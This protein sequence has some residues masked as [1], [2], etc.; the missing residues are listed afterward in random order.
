[1]NSSIYNTFALL[2]ILFLFNACTKVIDIELEEGKERI[3]IDA[4]IQWEKGTIGNE[5]SISL[6]TSLGYFDNGTTPVTGAEVNILNS[7]TGDTYLFQD[8]N[9]G[10]YSTDSF[11][12]I[13]MLL[14]P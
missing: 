2:S 6:S 13:L 8:Q 10:T 3:V 5:Q 14:T 4:S 1:M 7:N 9:N 12:P 11:V